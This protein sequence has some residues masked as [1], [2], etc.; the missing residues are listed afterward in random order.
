M[1]NNI[2]LHMMVDQEFEMEKFKN[3]LVYGIDRTKAF[4]KKDIK[5]LLG[6]EDL[7]KQVKIPKSSV[8]IPLVFDTTGS[9]FTTNQYVAEN[10][11]NLTKKFIPMFAKS[12]A[13]TAQP[14]TCQE[15]ECAGYNSGV[16]YMSCLSCSNT[17]SS[18]YV[19]KYQ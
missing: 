16:A 1:E 3:K 19:S 8:C 4:T 14:S 10:K 18:D 15:C 5:S 11:R 17:S 6:D 12:V 7:R 13:D 2:K 9:M